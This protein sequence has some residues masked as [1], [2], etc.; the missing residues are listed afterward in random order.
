V[1]FMGDPPS[2][3]PIRERLLAQG[4]RYGMELASAG[5]GPADAA[6]AF[7][8]FRDL[9]LK[10]VTEPRGRGGM[11]DERQVRTLLDVSGLLDEVFVAILHAWDRGPRRE[12]APSSPTST[13]QG[14]MQ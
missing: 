9:V 14:V 5:V 7:G 1:R 3:R 2:R 10:L 12:P 11:L 13:R 4:Q 8:F 6:E